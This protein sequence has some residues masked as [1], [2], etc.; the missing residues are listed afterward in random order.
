[1]NLLVVVFDFG[2]VISH[3]FDLTFEFLRA[4]GGARFQSVKSKKVNRDRKGSFK[5]TLIQK[6]PIFGQKCSYFKFAWIDDSS[7]VLVYVYLKLE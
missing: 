1:M 5:I 2:N 4:V 6:L 3:L 7:T